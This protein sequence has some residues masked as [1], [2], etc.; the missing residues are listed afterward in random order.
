MT[1]PLQDR[2]RTALGGR[3]LPP[4]PPGARQRLA[5]IAE[6]TPVRSAPVTGR[7]KQPRLV[8]GL[9]AVAAVTLA[10]VMLGAGRDR[11]TAVEPSASQGEIASVDGLRVMSVSEAIAARDAGE[12]PGDRVAM[13]G[14][15]SGTTL[16]PSCPAPNEPVG[17]LE[18]YCIDGWWGITEVDEP[19]LG[20]E[21]NSSQTHIWR[22]VKG[23]YLTP[24]LPP[25]LEH[26]DLLELRDVGGALPEPA[27]IIVLGHFDDF[28]AAECRQEARQVCRDRLVIDRIVQLDGVTFAWPSPATTIVPPPSTDLGEVDGLPLMTVSEALR[29]RDAGTLPDGRVA[30]HGYWTSTSIVHGCAPAFEAIG[31]LELYCHDG[32]FGI[33]ERNE[34][35]WV[36]DFR[37]GQVTYTAEGP[38]LTPWIPDGLVGA[39]GL[40]TL[41]MINGQWYPPV[42]IVVLGHF[43]DP[44]A[45]ECRPEARRLCRDR[46]VIDRIVRF[47]PEAV[48]TP[49]VTA[50]PTPFPSPGPPGLFEPEECAG[51]VPYSFVGWTTFEELGV[52]SRGEGHIWVA[53]TRDPVDRSGEWVDG[54]DGQRYRPYARVIC[55]RWEWDEGSMGYESIA[56]TEEIHWEDGR[57]TPGLLP[58]RPTEPG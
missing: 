9:A 34:P 13:R 50:P 22:A 53:I 46:L 14:F 29:A 24:W 51:D 44:R 2:V 16:M 6:T 5:A 21:R 40:Y 49:G 56:G 54:P 38:H 41:P 58:V 19:M 31:E 18:I 39:D 42:P 15:W 47:R 20:M 12:L 36:V 7:L 23:P 52:G 57:V 3:E 37:T 1:D 48:P 30:V 55:Y 8:L 17:D 33:T 28:R 11:S 25:D 32:E 27:P 43:D 4:A 10:V 35:I 45:A 26:G